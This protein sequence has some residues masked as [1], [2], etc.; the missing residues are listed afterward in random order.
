MIL[1]LDVKELSSL[2]GCPCNRNV[3]RAGRAIC[4]G[5]VMCHDDRDR[6][7]L[8][9]RTED[10]CKPHLR[11][12]DRANIDLGDSKHVRFCVEQNDAQM[13]LLEEFHI[14]QQSIRVT[15]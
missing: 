6:I 14:T 11:L 3:L 13:F 8:N 12:I 2:Y 10:F 7:A 1:Q 4:A 5:V 15:G 9:G